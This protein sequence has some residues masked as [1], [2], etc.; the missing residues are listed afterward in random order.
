MGLVDAIRL[1]GTVLTFAVA[2]TILAGVLA[3]LFPAFRAADAGLAGTLQSAGRGAVASERGGRLRGAL[4][5]GQFALAVVL[6]HAAGLL[7]HS[8]V[9]LTSVDPGFRT[10]GVLSFP[11]DLPPAE[12]GSNQ[13][14]DIFFKRLIEGVER[15]NGVLSVGAIHHLPI[16][17]A[18]RFLSRFRVEGRTPEGEEPSIGVRIVTPEYFQTIGV[19]VLQGRGIEDQDRAGGFP[20]VVINETAAA[21]FFG[22]EDPIGRRLAA[23]S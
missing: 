4:V 12:Y 13:R 6:L 8:F 9:R 23:F 7:L 1:D 11:I 17:S 15:Q 20:T 16:G 18:G 2:L 21:Q 3:G 5:V 14:V 22:N 19:P 10:E